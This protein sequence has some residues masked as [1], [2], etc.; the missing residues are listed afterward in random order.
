MKKHTV[1]DQMTC[2]DVFTTIK[3]NKPTLPPGGRLEKALNLSGIDPVPT[4]IAIA[5]KESNFDAAMVGPTGDLGLFQF[6]IPTA[7]DVQDRVVRNFL[8]AGTTI[9][10]VPAGARFADY[11]TDPVASAFCAWAFVLDKIARN[12]NKL[13]EGL[14]DYNPGE[15]GYGQKV[16]D[17]VNALRALCNSADGT[18]IDL[19]VLQTTMQNNCPGVRAALDGAVHLRH[20]G[21]KHPN[22]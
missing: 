20:T 1:R 2:A 4:L 18:P 6:L 9:P 11:R 7:D 19:G 17:G 21:R 15:A 3:D 8:P 12:N 10:H 22:S 5:F 13:L 14:N 16:L